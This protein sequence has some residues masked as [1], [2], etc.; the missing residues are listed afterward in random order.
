M[1]GHRFELLYALAAV[2]YIGFVVAYALFA[3]KF[4]AQ[5]WVARIV[6]AGTAPAYGRV[7]A[8]T[9]GGLALIRLASDLWTEGVRVR[10]QRGPRRG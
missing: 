9:L 1:R 7:F 3:Y 6:P 2:G 10:H 5:G 8:F 4:T